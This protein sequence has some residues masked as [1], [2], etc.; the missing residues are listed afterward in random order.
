MKKIMN[1]VAILLVL[2]QVTTRAQKVPENVLNSYEKV[3]TEKYTIEKRIF[4]LFDRPHPNRMYFYN[5]CY[6]GKSI[7]LF[8]LMAEKPKDWKFKISVGDKSITP[9]REL[10]EIELYDKKYY[11]NFIIV[12]FPENMSDKSEYCLNIIA[13]DGDNVDLPV[14]LYVFSVR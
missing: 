10:Q 4:P 5:E 3:Y 12:K 13:Y 2:T 1:L 11:S 14:Y 9:S 6:P 7:V 8:A